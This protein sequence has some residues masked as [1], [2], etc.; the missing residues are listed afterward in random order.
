MFAFNQLSAFVDSKVNVIVLGRVLLYFLNGH[1]KLINPSLQIISLLLV[2]IVIVIYLSRSFLQRLDHFRNQFSYSCLEGK[3]TYLLW[4]F[5]RFLDDIFAL[6][7][8]SFLNFIHHFLFCILL[9]VLNW[10]FLNIQFTN[11]FPPL[12]SWFWPLRIVLLALRIVIVIWRWV[13]LY[14]IHSVAWQILRVRL[15]FIL[16][17]VPWLSSLSW[18]SPVL[19]TALPNLIKFL[20]LY[21][22]MW[23]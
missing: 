21:F 1:I 6:L 8:R 17:F 3:P 16:S 20:F 5:R 4:R 10:H 23:H 15:L 7:L 14:C 2:I 11:L 13:W 18:N 22:Q 9:H 12:R 19:V